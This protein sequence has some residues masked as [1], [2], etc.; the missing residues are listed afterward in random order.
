MKIKDLTIP[1]PFSDIDWK[2]LTGQRKDLIALRTKLPSRSRNYELLS[3]VIHLMDYLTDLHLDAINNIVLIQN[4]SEMKQ[5]FAGE[6][7]DCCSDLDGLAYELAVSTRK[8][9]K[10][11]FLMAYPNTKF[12]PSDWAC[13][14]RYG[15]GNPFELK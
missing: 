7:Y 11:N 12:S 10:H 15:L 9:Y 13:L 6:I 8:T 4:Y 1:V 5:Y 14:K 2:F 3:G